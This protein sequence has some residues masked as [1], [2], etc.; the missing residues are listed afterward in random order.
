MKKL[1]FLALFFSVNLPLCAEPS[2]FDAIQKLAL[3]KQDY[4]IVKTPTGID[5]LSI[6]QF[7]NSKGNTESIIHMELEGPIGKGHFNRLEQ[8][9]R[10]LAGVVKPEVDPKHKVE[11]PIFPGL[12]LTV[13]DIN[14]TQV[15]LVDYKMNREPD[16]YVRRAILI[17]SKGLYSYSLVMHQS[18]PKSKADFKL[19]ALVITSVNSG[20][21]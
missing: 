12:G 14:G 10:F 20:Y 7:K 19:I 1:I 18:E 5:I 21:L 2:V 16:T 9:I 15:G 11:N 13:V 6:Q 3:F 17:S 8:G 4:Q